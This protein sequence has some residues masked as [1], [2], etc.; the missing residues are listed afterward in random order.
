M[1]IKQ[2][3]LIFIVLILC[4][5]CT[6]SNRLV[7]NSEDWRINN[8]LSSRIIRYKMVDNIIKTKLLIGKTLYE[9]INILGNYDIIFDNNH[10]RYTLGTNPNSI[11]AFTKGF[12]VLDIELENDIVINAKKNG[13]FN[14]IKKK[15]NKHDWELFVESR[16]TMSEDIIKINLLIGKTMEEVIEI[17]G[18]KECIIREDIGYIRYYLGFVPRLFAIDPDVLGITFENGKV[19]KVVQYET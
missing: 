12:S 9:V 14:Y 13:E 7:F 17:L 1:K 19:T 18:D 5:S 10:I 15:F 6:T 8:E 16:F 4:A 11:I 3:Y 2:I